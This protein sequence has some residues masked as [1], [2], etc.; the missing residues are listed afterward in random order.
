MHMHTERN[1]LAHMDL[2]YSPK[3][4]Q[5]QQ[6]AF[7]TPLKQHLHF[8]TRRIGRRS[9]AGRMQ[10]NCADASHKIS[11]RRRS[12][13]YCYSSAITVTLTAYG[14]VRVVVILQLWGYGRRIRE[15][16][17]VR[18]IVYFNSVRSTYAHDKILS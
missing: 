6:I 8:F 13:N 5:M 1:T 3:T 17:L 18:Y 14:R 2:L 12:N 9:V 15:T 10:N 4:V 16:T 11:H 7:K